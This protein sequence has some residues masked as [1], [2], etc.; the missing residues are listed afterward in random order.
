[1]IKEHIFW[2][3]L[4]YFVKFFDEFNLKH[5]SF[6]HL[7]NAKNALGLYRTNIFLL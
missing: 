3:C 4:N 2:N 6:N 1:M 5:I 7:K